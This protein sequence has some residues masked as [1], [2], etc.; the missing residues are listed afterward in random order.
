V[1]A[2]VWRGW[3]PR[4]T[5]QEYRRHYATDVAAHLRDVPGF[6]SA[7][8]TARDDGDLVEFTSTTTFTD[9][10]AI[11]A[12]AGEDPGAAVLE[13]AARRALVRWDDRVTHHEVAVEVGAA[14][15]GSRPTGLDH[16]GI[17]VADLDAAVDFWTR[18]MGLRLV[19]T[20]TNEGQGVREAMLAAG[21]GP[22]CVQLL[23]PLG[24]GSTIARFLQRNGP[25]LQQVAFRVPDVTA[26]GEALRNA[27]L[28]LTSS[29]PQP[30]T[31]GSLVNFVHPRD[32]GGVLVELVQPAD[33]G[34]ESHE[35]R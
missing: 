33:S 7:R 16:V 10:D 35:R 20:E 25:G 26:A 9:L 6:V 3:A 4:A 19:H 30:G 14:G 28:R 24:P 5:A 31:A 12:F 23:A 2:R 18:V 15:D 8:L 11:R 27:G 21:D 22:A 13:D 29:V 1:I 34:A 32:A 17:A